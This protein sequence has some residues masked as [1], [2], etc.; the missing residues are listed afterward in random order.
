M[1]ASGQSTKIENCVNGRTKKNGFYELGANWCQPVSFKWFK[2]SFFLLLPVDFSFE[3][4]GSWL[5]YRIFFWLLKKNN[6]IKQ[7]WKYVLKHFVLVGVRFT[8][9]FP[10]LYACKQQNTSR[11]VFFI[12]MV[13]KFFAADVVVVAIRLL[14]NWFNIGN[15]SLIKK[16]KKTRKDIW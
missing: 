2:S 12:F 9:Y 5:N 6:W 14:Y 10:S 8:S 15:I 16:K 1:N 7:C 13:T 11:T 3:L 4:F